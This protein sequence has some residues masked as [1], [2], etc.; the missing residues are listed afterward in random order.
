MAVTAHLSIVRSP[1]PAPPAG[2]TA[3]ASRREATRCRSGAP[4]GG[5]AAAWLPAFGAHRGG[6]TAEFLA[7]RR[8]GVLG[9]GHPGVVRERGRGTFPVARVRGGRGAGGS[10]AV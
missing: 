4:V 2:G 8:L 3:S 10:G 9:A 5:Q 1:V 7:P 6:G